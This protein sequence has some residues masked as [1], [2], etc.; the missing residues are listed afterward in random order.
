MVMI[1]NASCMQV[2][3][4]LRQNLKETETKLEAETTNLKSQICVLEE[5]LEREEQRYC[6]FCNYITYHI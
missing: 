6:S 1:A 4:E 2:L 5:S 3:E